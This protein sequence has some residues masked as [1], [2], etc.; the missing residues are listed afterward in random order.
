[1]LNSV[2]PFDSSSFD[3]SFLASPAE[4][5]AMLAQLG[6]QRPSRFQVSEAMLNE[7]LGHRPSVVDHP[8]AAA[9]RKTNLQKSEAVDTRPSGVPDQSRDDLSTGR[10][11]KCC[12]CGRCRRCLDN[13]RWDRIFSEKFADP[14]YYPL[15]VGHNSSLAGV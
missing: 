12:K 9:P 6:G 13:A 14:G 3:D 15:K 2:A 10:R 5:F 4:I 1:M 7:V 8:R 11:R